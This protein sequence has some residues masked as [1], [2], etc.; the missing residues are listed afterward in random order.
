MAVWVGAPVIA[1]DIICLLPTLPIRIFGTR[2][3]IFWPS[4]STRARISDSICTPLLAD[5][6]PVLALPD[7][8]ILRLV[9][10]LAM[11]RALMV[12]VGLEKGIVFD[13]VIGDGSA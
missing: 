2:V 12:R 10:G 7:A 3:W 11:G 4:T 9:S 6:V 8:E 1:A 13:R 5:I